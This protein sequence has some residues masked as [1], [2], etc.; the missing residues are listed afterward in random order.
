VPINKQD[1]YRSPNRLDQKRNVSCHIIIKTPNAQNKERILKAVREK[2]TVTYKASPVRITSDFSIEILKAKR[3]WAD[4]IQTLR[5]Q[6]CQPKILYP[7]KLSIIIDG[8]TK[9]FHDK[10]QFKQYLPQS[11][12]MQDNRR[13]SLG[14][15]LHPRESKK[16]TFT[17][18]K[19]KKKKSTQT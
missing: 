11:S 9:I 1:A 10:T 16:L 8:E 15:I 5:E 3:S 18:E 14:G 13:K 4:V 2:G 17:Y 19:I 6:Y 7:A 12:P